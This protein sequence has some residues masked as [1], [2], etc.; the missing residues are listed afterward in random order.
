MG[1]NIYAQFNTKNFSANQQKNFNACYD[2][3]QF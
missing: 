2:Q 3:T 1:G